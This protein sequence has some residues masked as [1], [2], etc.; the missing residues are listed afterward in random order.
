MKKK[1]I[2]I[3]FLMS[4]IVLSAMLFQTVHSYEHVYKQITEKPCVHHTSANNKQITHSHS[5]DTQCH[6]CHF[7]FSTFIPNPFQALT[8]NKIYTETSYLYFYTQ[9]A[10]TYF[11]GSLFALRAPPALV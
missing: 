2:I 9:T 10:S 4:L 11:K 8:F 6:I 5:V 1:V 7:A 3:N